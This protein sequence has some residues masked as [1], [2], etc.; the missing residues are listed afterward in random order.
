M[1]S[2][3]T[4]LVQRWSA[5][6]ALDDGARPPLPGQ[7]ASLREIESLLRE[8]AAAESSRPVG[9]RRDVLPRLS[10]APMSGP[11]AWNLRHTAGLT[12]AAACLLLAF[13]GLWWSIGPLRSMPIAHQ[14]PAIV[15]PPVQTVEVPPIN[16]EVPA[17]PP[18]S[19]VVFTVSFSKKS[20]TVDN[21]LEKEAKLLAADLDRVGNFLRSQ[22]PL[23]RSAQ[24]SGSDRRP[25]ERS[26]NDPAARDRA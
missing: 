1:L 14:P 6:R 8:E 24:S 25:G 20:I 12:L 11:A 7:Q 22:I 4:R 3:L 5:W 2:S 21:P 17:D 13:G 10:S 18:R 26:Q 23:S 9:L 19:R 16:P 15:K